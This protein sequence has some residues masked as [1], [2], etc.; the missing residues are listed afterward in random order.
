MYYIRDVFVSFCKYI[1]YIFTETA[2]N[3]TETTLNATTRTDVGISGVRQSIEI[4][5]MLTLFL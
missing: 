3:V 2:D 5:F 1:M 4:V